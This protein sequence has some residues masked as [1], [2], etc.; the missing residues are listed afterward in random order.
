MPSLHHHI[1]KC[2][3]KYRIRLRHEDDFSKATDF[4]RVY[5]SVLLAAGCFF[6]LIVVIF[7]G[8]PL[9]YCSTEYRAGISVRNA[10]PVLGSILIVVGFIAALC[11]YFIVRSV[12]ERLADS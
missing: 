4:I 12:R 2:V 6:G 10:F 8:D 9:T 11:S 5:W 3:G 7:A 1:K